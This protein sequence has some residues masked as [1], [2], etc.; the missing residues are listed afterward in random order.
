MVA[1][2]AA[3]SIPSGG[4]EGFKMTTPVRTQPDRQDL[5][6]ISPESGGGARQGSHV[7]ERL[8]KFPPS[9]WYAGK[10]MEDATVHPATR[11]GLQSLAAPYDLQWTQPDTLLFDS[12]INGLKVSRTFMPKHQCKPDAS[13]AWQ[14]PTH[15]RRSGD[16]EYESPR[17]VPFRIHNAHSLLLHYSLEGLW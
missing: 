2:F 4:K 13:N 6:K 17:G 15:L 16:G 12:P 9:L 14:I 8:R 3:T 10:P 11:N 5:F 1:N 7:L